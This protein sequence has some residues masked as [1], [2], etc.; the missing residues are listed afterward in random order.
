MSELRELE[1]VKQ[2]NIDI[3]N[4]ITSDKTT[5]VAGTKRGINSLI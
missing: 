2:E 4:R 5:S 3:L 1:N